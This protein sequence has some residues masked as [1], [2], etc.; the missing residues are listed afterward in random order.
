MQAFLATSP[1]Q[2]CLDLLDDVEAWNIRPTKT[3]FILNPEVAHAVQFC[4]K[5]LII[6]YR[7]MEPYLGGGFP[8]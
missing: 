4:A 2:S 6:S 5:D 1:D 8:K 7:D 3:G